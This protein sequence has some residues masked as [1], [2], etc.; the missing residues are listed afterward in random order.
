[1]YKKRPQNDTPQSGGF[2]E[3]RPVKSKI[4]LIT[5]TFFPMFS[6]GE[7]KTPLHIMQQHLDTFVFSPLHS[8]PSRSIA[9]QRM[10]NFL[11][12]AIIAIFLRDGLPRKIL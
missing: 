1:M 7:K 6:G 9:Q 12:T 10:S 4:R 5:S 2:Y 8:V 11:A 3:A